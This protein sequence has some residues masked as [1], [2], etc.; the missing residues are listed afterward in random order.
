MFSSK[1]KFALVAITSLIIS[2]AITFAHAEGLDSFKGMEGKIDIAGGTAHIPVMKGAAKLVMQSNP[3]I[4]ITVAGGGSGVGV[5]KVGEGLVDIGNAGRPLTAKEAEKYGLESFPFAIDGV[6][7]IIN[8][9]NKVDGLDASKIREIF[10]GAIT[11]WKEVGG[12]DAE[13]HLYTRDEASGTRAVFWKKLLNKGEIGQTA[14]VVSSNGSMKV[15][16]SNDPGAIGYMS[17]GH[18]DGSVKALAVDGVTP[19][20]ESAVSGKYPVVRKLFMNTKGA[21]SPLVKAFIDFIL[22]P[23]GA[24]LIRES[25]YLPLK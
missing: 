19:D 14:N 2:F 8:P 23:D 5:Q 11:N 6:A 21:P 10:S 1:R 18:L 12:A 16:V 15:A 17:I 4:R 7:P 20:Q 9:E 3:S 22:S 24:K 13:I 25:G